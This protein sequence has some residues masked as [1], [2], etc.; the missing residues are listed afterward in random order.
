MQTA[1]PNLAT[2]SPPESYTDFG[3]LADLRRQAQADPEQALAGVA[4][5][6]ESLFI[7][8]MLKS[9]REASFGDPYFDSARQA[10]YRDMFDNQISL[11]MAKGQ[12]IGLAEALMRQLRRY[13]PPSSRKAENGAGTAGAADGFVWRATAPQLPRPGPVSA[14]PTEPGPTD[15]APPGRTPAA[16]TTAAA[17]TRREPGEDLPAFAGP[18]DF[19]RRL[20]PH[21]EQAGRE[22]GV[23]PRAL[24]AQAALETGWG[25]HISRDAEGRS[26]HNLFNIKADGRWQGPAVTVSTLEFRDGLPQREMA[27][28]R[29]Y[30]SF[31]DSFRDYVQFLRGSPRYRQALERADDPEAFVSE[32]QAAGYATDPRYADKIIDILR[33]DTLQTAALDASEVMR[34]GG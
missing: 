17:S 33:R 6:F 23:S 8:M 22:L 26:S 12:G 3:G 16:A 25:K 5:Q 30:D 2:A 19:V 29:A 7:K 10:L 1:I 9:M 24:L 11:D 31:A 13:L 15:P 21:A 28:F 4:R 18:A 32:L 20:W 14:A 34:H 27:R